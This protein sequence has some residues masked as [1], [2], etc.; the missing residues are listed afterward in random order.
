MVKKR[1]N[2]RRCVI[3][4]SIHHSIDYIEFSVL[5]INKS[6]DFYSEAFGWEFTDYAPT[7]TGIKSSKGEMGGFSLVDKVQ[8]G[9]PLV[10]LYSKNL[11]DSLASVEKAGGVIIK[12]IFEFP[13]GKRFEFKDPNGNN[14]AVWSKIESQ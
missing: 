8:T 4:N 11:E 1:I 3:P 5:D 6:K 7:Y 14:L 2:Y 10:V 13:G 12:K 9:G